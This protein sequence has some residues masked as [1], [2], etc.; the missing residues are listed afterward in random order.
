M[1][2]LA[3]SCT[4]KTPTE[5]L[6]AEAVEAVEAVEAEASTDFADLSQRDS[7]TFVV[8]GDSGVLGEPA[9]QVGQHIGATCAR[10][11]CDF[12]LFTGDNVYPS[13][14]TSADDEAFQAAFEQPFSGM[15][16]LRSWMV[17][18]NHDHR[19]DIQAQIDY[20][21]ERWAMPARH[22]QVPGLPDW[23][24]LYGW[25]SQE[26]HKRPDSP[27]TAEML[28]AMKASLCSSTGWAMPFGHHPNH[29]SGPHGRGDELDGVRSLTEPIWAEC[30]VQAS[31]S[32]HDHHLEVLKSPGYLSVISGAG[33]SNRGVCDNEG[34]YKGGASCANRGGLNQKFLSGELGYV[35]ITATETT[36][37]LD[38]YV[39]SEVEPVW[40][41]DLTR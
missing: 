5:A 32:G 24:V 22:Y 39:V 41:M 23:L 18:G 27:E 25:D 36:A 13:G 4:G 16:P 3:L 33:S 29:S 40:G 31:F 38:V 26:A 30:G 34:L 20:R 14:V 19:G 11:G 12:A 28:A 15:G 2:L 7:L 8:L 21:S 10:V 35:L 37:R 6:P 1:L 9:V 17:L